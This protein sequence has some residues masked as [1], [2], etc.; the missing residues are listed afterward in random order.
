MGINYNKKEDYLHINI[1]KTYDYDTFM[2][3]L[4]KIKIE[5]KKIGY[6]KIIIDLLESDSG[7]WEIKDM[8]RFYIGEKIVD[9]FGFPEHVKIALICDKKYYDNF[10]ETVTSNRGVEYKVFFNIEDAVEWL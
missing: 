1:K 7:N 2:S 8:E 4:E 5:T 3:D 10:V 9:L 6:K